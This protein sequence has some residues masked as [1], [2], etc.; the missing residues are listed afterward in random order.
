[1]EFESIV[2]FA[3]YFMFTEIF[4]FVP[5]TTFKKI[6]VPRFFLLNRKELRFVEMGNL[7]TF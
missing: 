3:I 7:N 2:I 6:F 1:M 5:G 4:S